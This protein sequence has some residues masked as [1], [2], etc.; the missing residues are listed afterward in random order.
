MLQ[1]MPGPT[2]LTAGNMA[3]GGQRIVE[4]VRIDLCRQQP[5]LVLN[6][7][8]ALQLIASRQN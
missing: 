5:V 6:T 2:G 4:K 8:L 1:Q 7:Q 3:N